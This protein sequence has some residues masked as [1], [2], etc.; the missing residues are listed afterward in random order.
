[1][2]RKTLI[3]EYKQREIVGG[4]FKITNTSNG[5][6]YMDAAPNIQAKK[7]SFSF[8]V[9]TNTC[10]HHKIKKDWDAFGGKSFTFEILETIKKKEDQSREAFLD[11]LQA[12]KQM[13]N[14]KTDLTGS[15]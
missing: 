6:F 9:S 1:M 2:D 7:N 13:W 10:F 11:D 8:M 3:K 4:I 14:D 5:M 12:L 15:Y